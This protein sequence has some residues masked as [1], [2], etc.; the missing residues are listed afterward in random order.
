MTKAGVVLIAAS[1]LS[2]SALDPCADTTL[3][4]QVNGDSTA[5]AHLYTRDCGATTRLA[6]LVDIKTRR[7]FF[8]T[9]VFASDDVGD[10]V[11]IW[12]TSPVELDVEC[13]APA[14]RRRP[15]VRLEAKQIKVVLRN[16]SLE[17][18]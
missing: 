18:K 13:A 15:N 3:S 8:W 9:R 1:L 5:E 14:T 6:Y 17:I 2:C 10:G 7:Q 11:R 16:C 12:W 4:K